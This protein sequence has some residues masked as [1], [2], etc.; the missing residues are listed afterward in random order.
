MSAFERK[1]DRSAAARGPGGHSNGARNFE[2]L[3]RTPQLPWTFPGVGKGGLG[4]HASSETAANS[5]R[6]EWASHHELEPAQYLRALDYESL[7]L[8]AI[9]RSVVSRCACEY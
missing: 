7:R 4:I 9:Q 2:R 5:S 6:V 1:S 3:P 8:N